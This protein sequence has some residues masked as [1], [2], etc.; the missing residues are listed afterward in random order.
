MVYVVNYWERIKQFLINMNY[1]N[2]LSGTLL[3]G[4]SQK[5][6]H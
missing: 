2:F 6:K 4:L 3:N 1:F 5:E